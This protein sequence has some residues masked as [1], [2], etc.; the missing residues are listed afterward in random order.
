MRLFIHGFPGAYGGA[1]VE[2]HH[3]IK[4]WHKMGLDLHII[5]TMNGYKNEP[6]YQEMLS[7]NVT[8]HESNDFS[9]IKKED[10]IINFCSRTFL[11]KLPEIVKYTRRTIFVNCMTWI[12]GAKSVGYEKNEEWN[13]KEGN[14]A[15]SLYQRPQIKEQHEAILRQF[16]SQAQF[17]NFKPYFDPG[18][19]KF[20]PDRNF[21]RFSIGRISRQDADKF[22]KNLWHIWEGVHSPIMKQGIVLGWDER[23]ERKC[24]KPLGWVKTHINQTSL[25]VKDFWSSVNII[26]QPTETTEN[27]PRIGFEAMYAGVPLIVDNRG[28]WK[29]LIEHGKTG[30]LCNHERDFMYY[31]SHLAYNPELR[32]EIATAAFDRAMELSSYEESSESWKSVFDKVYA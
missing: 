2:L 29:Y 11:E 3:Q 5:P 26:L 4:C 30:F 9:S 19:V 16:R 31:A 20:N 23:S 28:G 27:W 6:L 13:H 1:S 32:R 18:S 12:F 25:P 8:I 21:D 14:I 10:A 7:L 15:F 17:L 22:T 24:G